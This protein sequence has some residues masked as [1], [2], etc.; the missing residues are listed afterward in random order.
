MVRQHLGKEVRGEGSNYHP[1]NQLTSAICTGRNSIY[2]YLATTQMPHFLVSSH[3]TLAIEF[4]RTL[5]RPFKNHGLSESKVK[6]E[7]GMGRQDGS[8]RESACLEA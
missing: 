1:S 7:Q 3:F 5:E 8:A 2:Y 6:Y 4:Q